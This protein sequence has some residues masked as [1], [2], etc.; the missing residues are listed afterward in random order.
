MMWSGRGTGW[1][2]GRGEG[3]VGRGVGA[4]MDRTGSLDTDFCSKIQSQMLLIMKMPKK[5][6]G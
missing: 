5:E 4:R 6:N 2:G 3:G 1:S